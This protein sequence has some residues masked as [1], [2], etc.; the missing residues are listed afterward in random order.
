MSKGKDGR[1][2]TTMKK[3]SDK[4]YKTGS[5]ED[6]FVASYEADHEINADEADSIIASDYSSFPVTNAS[7]M[8]TD[9]KL[10]ITYTVDHCN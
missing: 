8:M 7:Y 10:V 3:I 9:N 1:K 2:E 5:F 6:T 4:L